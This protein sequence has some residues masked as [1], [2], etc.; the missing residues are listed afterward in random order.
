MIPYPNSVEFVVPNLEFYSELPNNKIL[1]FIAIES[2][3]YQND[4]NIR[5]QYISN[6]LKKSYNSDFQSILGTTN[7]LDRDDAIKGVDSSI[8]AHEERLITHLGS[9]TQILNSSPISKATLDHNKLINKTVGLVMFLLYCHSN[10]SNFEQKSISSRVQ[11]YKHITDPKRNFYW[12]I[13][14]LPVTVRDYCLARTPVLHLCA[15]RFVYNEIMS[16]LINLNKFNMNQTELDIV[17]EN[18]RLNKFKF[19]LG[20][21]KEFYDWGIK[22]EVPRRSEYVIDSQTAWAIPDSLTIPKSLPPE[23]ADFYA[24][25]AL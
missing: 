16:K 25:F 22:K 14:F 20:F 2:W 5:N 1:E 13:D 6:E 18:Y 4:I 21:A 15:G 19:I 10:Y 23:L 12:G 8:Y 17:K 9:L 24:T 7:D 3:P 11:I